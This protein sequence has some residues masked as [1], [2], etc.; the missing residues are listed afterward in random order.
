MCIIIRH[1]MFGPRANVHVPSKGQ[2]DTDRWHK[3]FGPG[4]LCRPEVL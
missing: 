1:K 2:Q 4:D 3:K